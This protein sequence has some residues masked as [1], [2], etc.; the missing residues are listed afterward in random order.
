MA[1]STDFWG[2]FHLWWRL[3]ALATQTKP[4]IES[5]FA[6]R[7]RQAKKRWPFITANIITTFR[8][9]PAWLAYVLLTADEPYPMTA[10]VVYLITALMDWLDG[11]W[12]RAN[13]ENSGKFGKVF[14][15]LIDKVIVLGFLLLF[16]HQNVFSFNLFWLITVLETVST[17]IY[18]ARIDRLEGANWFGGSKKVLQDICVLLAMLGWTGLAAVALKAAIGLS[19]ASSLAKAWQSRPPERLQERQQA[20]CHVVRE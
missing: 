20:P 3:R 8:A 15:P 9:F 16:A 12:A 14:D 10:A 17:A 4:W 13:G 2:H 1:K 19:V 7:L 6:P 18:F 11:A 5:W